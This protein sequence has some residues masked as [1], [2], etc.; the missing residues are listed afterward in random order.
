[1]PILDFPDSMTSSIGDLF[2]EG[3]KTWEYDGT[4]W[5]LVVGPLELATNSVTSGKIFNGS[6]LETKLANS[7]VTTHK[8]A[9]S[10]VTTAKLGDGSV[11]SD[12]LATDS[13]V[14]IAIADDAITQSKMSDRAIGSAELGNL[15][16]NAQLGTSYTL[17]LADAHKVVTLSNSAPTTVAIPTNDAV[18]FE[19]GD[20]IN[21]L[22]LGTGDVVVSPDSGVTLNSSG[23]KYKLFGQY[24]IGTLLKVSTNEWVFLG[25]I[26][27]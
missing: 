27:E 12:K 2:T 14:T 19:I 17:T 20:Q 1:M 9:N 16:L 23:A 15:S 24:A 8:I 13:V 21:L 10:A 3:G 26:K 4:A 22:Q 6:V 25:N 11:T 7:A 18:A 5:N